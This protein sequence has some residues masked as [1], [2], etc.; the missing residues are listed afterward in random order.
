MNKRVSSLLK[1]F[2][3]KVQSLNKYI[4]TYAL[5]E[6]VVSAMKKKTKLIKKNKKRKQWEVIAILTRVVR[7]DFKNKVIFV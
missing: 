1:A 4:N 5:C 6:I 7:V 2:Q 3:L